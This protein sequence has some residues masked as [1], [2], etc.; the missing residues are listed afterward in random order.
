MLDWGREFVREPDAADAR[1]WLSTNGLGGFAAGTVSGRLAR[2]YHGL[3]IAALAP[4]LGRTLLV[5]KT[6]DIA[7]YGGQTFALSA[8]RWADGT[9]APRGDHLIERFRLD[10]TV[11]VWTYACA[12]A[13]VERRVWMAQGANTTYV[14]YRLV[15]GAEPLELALRVLVNYRDYHALTR[16]GTW[17]MRVEP[18]ADGVRVTAFDGARPVLVLAEGA[19][20]A[21][22]NVWYHGVRLP[23][24][25]ARGLDSVEDHLHAATVT[26]RVAPGEALTLVLSAETAPDRD[27]TAAR[28]RHRDHEEAVLGAWRRHPRGTAAAPEWI[29]RLVLAADQ[30]IVRRGTDGLSVIAGYPWFGDWG[31]DTMVSLPGLTLVTG[32]SELTRQILTTFAGFVDR[33][34]LPNRFPDAGDV[35]EYNTV[36]AALWFIEAV[37]AYDEA[38]KDVTTLAALLPALEAI[39]HGYREGT[40]YGIREDPTDHLI[41]AGEPGVQVT[42][43]D[44]KVGDRV[45]TPR[46]GK[47]VEVN[48]LWYNALCAMRG[49]AQRL[50]RPTGSWESLAERVQAGF[51]RFWN[52]AAGCCFDVLDGPEGHDASIRPN[53]IL[54]VS[55]PASPL[56]AAR[57]RQVVDACARRLATSYGLRS[58]DSDDPRYC[59]RYL[60]DSQGRDGAYHQGTAWAWLMG[61]FALAHFRVYQDRET[62]LAL[63]A[64]L[65]QHLGD[66]GLG[67][68]SEIFDGAAPHV[69]RGCPQQAWSVA[70]V[71]RGWVQITGTKP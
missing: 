26:A 12:E 17:R 14:T 70:E 4:P 66:A 8:D 1:E 38:T 61:P 24:E 60:G 65:A 57:Q 3:L 52:G 20:V 30:F 56:P 39:V 40:R 42:W 48:A 10:G 5:A 6:E 28:R 15:R 54:A 59:G 63:L 32:R 22:A 36:D 55:L 47:A 69:P 25:A 34:M 67:S 45:I 29:E 53:Q 19:P 71:L 31:R 43:M 9:L 50:G 49:F 44:A 46:V 41:F 64:P 37:R 16:A 21:P 68:V 58:L 35:P 27:G 11:P 13:R 51:D 62:A 23:L 2:R 7:T 33:G 18:V